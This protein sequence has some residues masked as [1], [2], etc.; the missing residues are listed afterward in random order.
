MHN[1]RSNNVLWK[2][3]TAGI[4]GGLVASWVINQFQAAWSKAVEG[5]EKPHGAQ[6]M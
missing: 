3:L 6:S 4:A 1:G 2:G 5:F